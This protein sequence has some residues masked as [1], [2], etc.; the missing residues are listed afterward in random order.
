MKLHNLKRKI[1]DFSKKDGIITTAEI[2]NQFDISWNTAE[3]Y[4]LE[5]TLDNKFKRIKKAGVNLWVL[6]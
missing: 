4:L 2:A 3:K 1:L 6:K 5:M